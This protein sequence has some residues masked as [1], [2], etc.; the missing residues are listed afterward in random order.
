MS[1]NI[2]NLDNGVDR[3]L[4]ISL[5]DAIEDVIEDIAVGKMTHTEVVG[6]LEMIKAKYTSHIVEHHLSTDDY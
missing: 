6:T 2:V 3:P 4:E 5:M 1:D